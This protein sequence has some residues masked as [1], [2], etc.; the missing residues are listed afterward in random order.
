MKE[1]RENSVLRKLKKASYKVVKTV[2]KYCKLRDTAPSEKN[3]TKDEYSRTMDSTS[4]TTNQDSSNKVSHSSDN[5]DNG[6]KNRYYWNLLKDSMREELKNKGILSMLYFPCLFVY[7]ELCFHLLVFKK[8]D[9][10]IIYPMFMGIAMGFILTAATSIWKEKINRILTIV[11]TVIT[12]IWFSVQLVYGHIFRTFLSLYSVGENG[13]DVLEFWREALNGILAKLPGIFILLLPIPVLIILIK[14]VSF[15][16]KRH[17]LFAGVQIL[18][19]IGCYLTFLLFLLLPGKMPHTPYDLY[20]IDFNQ[21]LGIEKIGL[22][23]A[24]CFDIRNVVFGAPDFKMGGDVLASVDLPK[25][26]IT[27]SPTKA[28]TSNKDVKSA[29]TGN[30]PTPSPLPTPT[31]ID[32]SPNVVNIDF[33][34]LAEGENDVSIKNLHQYFSTVTPTNKNEYTGMFEGYN[35]IFL[36]AEGFS[37]WAVDPVVTPTLYK[38]TH[39]GFVFENFYTPIWWTSTSDGEFVAC[40]G[41]IPNG[42]N[43]FTKSAKGDMPLCLGWQFKELGYS[44]RAYHDHSYKYY[45]RNLSHP[46]MGYDYKGANGGGLEVKPTWPESDLEMMQVTLPEYIKDEKFHTY[47][48]TV[49]GHMEYNFLGNSMSAKNRSYVEGLPYSDDCKAYIACNKELDLALEYLINSLDKAGVLDKTVIVMSADHYPYGLTMDEINELAGHKVD[50]NFELYKNNLILWN[51]KIKE[52]IVVDKF[53][54]SLD[55]M[56]TINNLFGIPYDSRL[57]MGQDILSD[58]PALVMM[59]N[60]SFITDH[61]RYNSK[62][63]EVVKLDDEELPEN[64][65]KAYVNIVRNKF[66]VSG[67]MIK[68][69]YYHSILKYLNLETYDKK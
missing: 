4:E 6:K 24:T 63:G 48:M 40:T 57:F 26:T 30:S 52:P 45:N 12:S 37:P 55:I 21:D 41:L 16:E 29:S 28:P 19:G 36:T 25:V 33:T 5:K 61:I 10:N 65:V 15:Q 53:C 9:S 67:S 35:L 22:V 64:Y 54:S 47:Y 38:L 50:E 59:S 44:T 23:T 18:S 2:Q 8:I 3:Y 68:N 58:A 43:S 27:L 39:S 60:Q 66:N 1:E 32:T 56:P 13:G 14:R 20:H 46:N 62:T 51:S 31:P 17:P 34:K 42:T 69:N 7:L 49:S 11:L